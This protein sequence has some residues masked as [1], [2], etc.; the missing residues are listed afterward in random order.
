MKYS[1]HTAMLCASILA[2]PAFAQAPDDAGDAGADAIIVTASRIPLEPRQIGSAISIVSAEELK[3]GQIR[4]VKDA[5]LDLPGLYTSTDRPGDLTSVS[6]RGSDNDQVLWLIDGIKLGD[7]SSTTTQFSPEH[8]VT[9]DIARIEVL[10][11]NQSSLYGAD[12]IGGV[13]NIITQRA[14]GEGVHVNAEAEGGSYG[15]VNGGAS[16]LGKHGPVDFRLTATGYSHDGPSLADPR[17]ATRPVTEDD[18]YSRYGFSGRLGIALTNELSLQALGFW[19]QAFSDLDNSRSDSLDTVRKREYAAAV[20]ANYLSADGRFKADASVTRYLARR[21]YFGSSYLPYGDIY[22][23]TKDAANVNFGYNGGIVD[24]AVG[25][26]LEREKADLRTRDFNLPGI[27]ADFL[28]V[29]TDNKAA[30]AE[31]ALHPIENLT[32]TGAARIDDNSR[33]GSFDTYRGTIAYVIPEVAGANNVKL[34]ASYGT[35][36]KAPGL[37]QLF[38]PDYGNP[39]LKVET[40]EGGDF[41]FDM[42]FDRFTAQLSYFFNRTK[43]EIVFN[44]TGG[45]LG[46][47]GYSQFGHTRKNGVEVAFELKPV[48]GIAIRQSFTYLDVTVDARDTG[49]F[50]RDK[51]RPRHIGSTSVTLT[52]IENLTLTARVRYRSGIDTSSAF[53]GIVAP[54]ATVDLLASYAITPSIEVYGRVTNLLD[55]DYQVS[56][57][58]N[59]LDRAAYGGVRVSF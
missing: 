4:F 52:A 21:A 1:I 26:S 17:T 15:A 29:R 11:G 58:K 27:A 44:S 56:F 7:P 9:R 12:A 3:V 24:I 47:G 55:K 16:V 59:Q 32:V 20:Q 35:G 8:L 43:N 38:S 31:V 50:L 37:Y 25:G 2:T 10:R 13:I 34:R 6:I 39:N 53:G 19:Q 46:N 41:G 54:Y 45:P 42:N 51:G 22:K 48:T 28:N 30:Y 5:L 57:G 33:F 40:G 36:A 18:R 49:L 23:G 14:T